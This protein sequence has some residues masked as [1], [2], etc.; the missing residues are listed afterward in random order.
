MWLLAWLTSEIRE[1]EGFAFDRAIILAMRVSG[2]PERPIGP[3][4]LPSAVRDVTALGSTTVLTLIVALT[5][6]FLMMRGMKRPAVLLILATAGGSVV[7]TAFKALVSRARPDIIERLMIETS[8]SFPSGHAANSAIVYLTLASLVWPL[9]QR[10]RERIFLLAA[11]MMLVGAI[12][13]S[14]VYLGVHWPSD[15]LA[16]WIFG[17]LWALGWWW[18]ELR[19]LK[20]ASGD[21]APSGANR[22]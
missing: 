17:S 14:R 19:L 8:H 6:L 10:P 12:G 20:R 9:M 1:G 2:H 18:I 15:V 5:A 21:E 3:S 4:W 22:Q 16:G 11:M 13:I 7:I